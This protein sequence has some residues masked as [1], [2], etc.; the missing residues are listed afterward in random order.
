MARLSYE[1]LPCLCRIVEMI[2]ESLPEAFGHVKTDRVYCVASMGHRGASLA[3]IHGMSPAWAAVGMGPAYLIEIIVENYTLLPPWERVR[4]II[5]ELLH[6]PRTFS[7]CLRPHGRLVNERVVRRLEGTLA[8]RYPETFRAILEE[9]AHCPP[10]GGPLNNPG[11]FREPK[12]P[13]L[14]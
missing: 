12:T 2:V 8:R 13:G 11:V 1:P 5:H 9:A 14:E 7:G 4:V 3:R 10:P 6:I